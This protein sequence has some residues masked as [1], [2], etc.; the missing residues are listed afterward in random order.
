M[1]IRNQNQS[2]LLSSWVL[3]SSL[4]LMPPEPVLQFFEVKAKGPLSQV[5]QSMKGTA[6]SPVL[7]PLEPSLPTTSF[8]ILF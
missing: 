3:V 2:A 7:M 6:S 1:I 8:G 4:T 5:L